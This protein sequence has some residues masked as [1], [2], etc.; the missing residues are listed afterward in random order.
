M[1]FNTTTWFNHNLEFQGGYEHSIEILLILNR[2]PIHAGLALAM[3]WNNQCLQIWR[4]WASIFREDWNWVQSLLI[5]AC[6]RSSGVSPM[7]PRLKFSESTHFYRHFITKYVTVFMIIAQKDKVEEIGKGKVRFV[8]CLYC[9]FGYDSFFKYFYLSEKF[10][11][12]E[13]LQRLDKNS[14][15]FVFLPLHSF[16]SFLWVNF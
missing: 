14:M 10:C 12:K 16:L 6:E 15:I 7:A 5:N 11:Y 2:S 13:R 4:L 1:L 3:K 8:C 9:I